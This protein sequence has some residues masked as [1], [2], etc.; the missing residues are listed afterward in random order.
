MKNFMHSWSSPAT[1]P[2]AAPKSNGLASALY[3]PNYAATT[4]NAPATH[5]PM[6][7]PAAHNAQSGSSYQSASTTPSNS[8]SYANK[9]KQEVEYT[10][11]RGQGSREAK[12]S[13]EDMIDLTD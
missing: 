9:V 1:E 5:V 12:G 2:L 6:T 13:P 8:T 3:R 10:S 4:N 11:S 7:S